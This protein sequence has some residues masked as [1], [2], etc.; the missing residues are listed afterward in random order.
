MIRLRRLAILGLALLLPAVLAACGPA[1][2]NTTVSPYS[3]G[4]A[5]YVTYGTVIGMQPV[6]VAGT[7]SGLGAG[8]GAVGGGLI[9]STIGGDWRARTVGAVAGGLIGGIGGAVVEE[10]V[11]SGQ[12]MQFIIRQDRGD[13]IT[14]VQTNEIGLRPGDRVAISHG[15]RIR[16]ARADNV[17]PPPPVRG[18]VR[19]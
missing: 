14:V 17:A 19:K 4:T 13:D 7:R 3:V 9:G 6:Q 18:R 1:A 16:L 12:A 15:D 5:G 10:G 8:A 11:T 2:G